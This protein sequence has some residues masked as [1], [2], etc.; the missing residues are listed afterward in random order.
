MLRDLFTAVCKLDTAEFVC[1]I[2]RGTEAEGVR[3]WGAEE[4]LWPQEG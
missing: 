1:Q 4:D 3:K 2:T